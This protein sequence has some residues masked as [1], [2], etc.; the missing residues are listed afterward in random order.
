MANLKCAMCGS[1]RVL[2]PTQAGDR[3]NIDNPVSVSVAFTDTLP[4][5]PRRKE[6][7]G[8]RRASVCVDCGH[9]AFFVSEGIRMKLL[10]QASMLQ[11]TFSDSDE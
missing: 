8:V 7:S 5:T 4:S 11:A 3:F 6:F 2:G 10:E 1:P 9:I